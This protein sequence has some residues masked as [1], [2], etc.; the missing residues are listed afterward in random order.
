MAKSPAPPDILAELEAALRRDLIRLTEP[1][2]NGDPAPSLT[3]K[4]K[5]YDRVLKLAAIKAKL[6]DNE[7]GSGFADDE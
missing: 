5:V 3:D 4:M 2:R 7:F 1:A 6:N